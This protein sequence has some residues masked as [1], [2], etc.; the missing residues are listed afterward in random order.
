MVREKAVLIFT[1]FRG[2]GPFGFKPVSAL[3]KQAVLT[4]WNQ[5]FA[6]L[7]PLPDSI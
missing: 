7:P 2:M 4:K 1:S 5:D 3:P 6:V